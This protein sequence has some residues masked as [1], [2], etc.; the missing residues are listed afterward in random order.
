M[1]IE[2]LS[3]SIGGAAT[4][5]GAIA[6]ALA[7]L[8]PAARTDARRGGKGLMDYDQCLDRLEQDI[9][10]QLPFYD[11]RTCSRAVARCCK[12][13]QLTLRNATRCVEQ[14]LPPRR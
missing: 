12:E 1:D 14:G 4:R 11:R 9:C 3:R 8:I 2:R 13:S 6:A 5:R 10:R 7:V